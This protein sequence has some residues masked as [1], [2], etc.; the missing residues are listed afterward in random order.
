MH[1]D[2]A[3]FGPVHLRVTNRDKAVM[4][5]VEVI[6][7]LVRKSDDAVELG[8]KAKTLVVLHQEAKEPVQRGY[9]GLYHLAVHVPDEAEFARILARFISLEYPISPVDHTFSKAIY[10]NDPDGIMVEITL[11]T[12]ERFV[13]YEFSGKKITLRD[14]NGN[15]NG[16]SEQLDGETVLKQ[17]PD[18]DLDRKL[19]DGTVIGHV[20]LHVGDL[21][22]A[23]VFYEEIGFQQHLFAP[24]IGFAD[25]SAGGLFMHRMAINT[26]QGL[27]VPQTPSHHA[28]MKYFTVIFDSQDRL[29][30]VLDRFPDAISQNDGFVTK[31]PSGNEILFTASQG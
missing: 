1:T 19:P 25:F 9:S 3:A 15:Q 4:F 6:G 26:W 10:L 23:R 11:E 12:P 14:T 8:T 21:E 2:F 22:K 27:N 24:Q 29:R 16:I 20:H 5:W 13:A 18:N 17:L 30:K 31:D 28:G 7:L